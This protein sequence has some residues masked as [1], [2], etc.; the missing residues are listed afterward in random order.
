MDDVSQ[1][2]RPILLGGYDSKR[3]PVRV[4]NDHSPLVPTLVWQP[5]RAEQQ[6]LDAGVRF[7]AEMF[8]L[9]LALHPG[10]ILIDPGPGAIAATLAAM[11]AAA[12]LVLG[13]WLP[14]DAD[15]GRKG[16]PDILIRVG[17]GYLPG[18]VKHH[19]P[20]HATTR[21]TAV[22]SP[23]DSPVER[24]TVTG[25][26]AAGEYRFDDGIQLAHY[27]RMLQACGRHGGE[28]SGAVLGTTVLP[29]DEDGPPHPVLVWH[30]LDE[31]VI[32]TFS[33]S[34][35][36][37]KRSLLQRY[38]HEHGFRLRV[39][40][41]ARMI[42]GADDDPPALVDP[43]GQEECGSCPYGQYCADRM[44]PEEPSTQITIGRLG[45]REWVALRA[46]G[47]TTTTALSAVDPEDPDFL[48]D[49]LPEV[50]D[51]GR[52]R[53]RLAAAVRRAQMICEGIEITRTADDPLELP[54]ADVEI[55]LD[56]EQDRDNRVYMWGVRIRSGADESTA[57]YLDDFTEWRPLDAEG[58][59]ELA[60]RF[61]D[62]LHDVRADAA[63]RGET[64]RVYHWSHPEASG[65][66][67]IM[68]A[69]EVNDLIA[70]VFTDLEK[71]FLA[72]FFSL[73]GS[74]L[75][76]IAPIFGFRWQVADP[77]GDTSRL[78]LDTVHADVDPEAVV[79]AKRWLLSYNRDDTAATA[80]I[81]DGLRAWAGWARAA[82]A[83][84]GGSC[85]AQ[86]H[87]EPRRRQRRCRTP[88]LADTEAGAGRRTFRSGGG[89]V[90]R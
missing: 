71:V 38:D 3:C 54:V 5:S 87:P 79:A 23:L 9:L 32:T 86:P 42:V 40:A 85:S 81:R 55:D 67:R 43:I 90:G 83:I 56:I 6:R 25:W 75:K 15:G 74:K 27:T 48:A 47:V 14:D 51:S 11:D 64:V 52:V 12:P 88:R 65:L 49:Y 22:V 63:A 2:G 4:H 60:G 72:N 84:A 62:W 33:R 26:S 68:G 17:D 10:A 45:L 77:G 35:G 34:R 73:R 66:R 13:G 53:A 20:L 50:G 70:E 8:A 58:E 16:R 46:M 36:T 29:I 21:T 80:A 31:P 18:D 76:V 61:I 7:E 28:L 30:N 44:G 57:R 24:R 41:N 39:A 59:R 69:G 1:A 37:A 82:T 78:Y 89:G 19:T